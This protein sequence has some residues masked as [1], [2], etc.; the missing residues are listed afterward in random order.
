MAHALLHKFGVRAR[1][2]VE[3]DERSPKIVLADTHDPQRLQRGKE[4]PSPNVLRIQGGPRLARKD[5]VERVGPVQARTMRE[6]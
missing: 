1:F 4:V 3:R 6:Q 5:Q 2:H